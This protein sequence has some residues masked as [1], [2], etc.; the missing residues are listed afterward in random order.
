MEIVFP[1]KFFFLI[2]NF[3][4]QPETVLEKQTTSQYTYD[5]CIHETNERVFGV[6][7]CCHGMPLEE[8]Q[9]HGQEENVL[10]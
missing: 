9:Y 5:E 1:L 7:E 8:W 4:S 3:F 2:S 6:R 10:T